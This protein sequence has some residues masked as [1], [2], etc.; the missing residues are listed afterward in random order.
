MTVFREEKKRRHRERV[1]KSALEL[2]ESK[3][4][5]ATTMKEI[6]EKAELA[7]GTLYNY[8]PSKNALLL[9]IFEKKME[10]IRM[11]NMRSV[12]AIFRKESNPR[13]I[14]ETIFRM[15]MDSFFILSKRNWNEAMSAFFSVNKDIE[16]GISLDMQSIGMIR[17]V[18]RFMQKRGLIEPR[19][20]SFTIAFNFYSILAI[21]FMGY[22]YIPE[23]TEED[24]FKGISE[25]LE[26]VFE[27]IGGP[28]VKDARRHGA[29]SQG[30]MQ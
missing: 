3:G 24:F 9:G 15:A 1:F 12:A 28:C 2:F 21:Q 16:K 8:F 18:V 27:G 7:V 11:G 29:D 5:S 19:F 10:E 4:F 6:S 22:V 17:N 26:L 13:V 14:V 25:Q 20:S 30:G 23:T